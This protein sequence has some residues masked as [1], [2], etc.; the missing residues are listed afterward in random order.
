MHALFGADLHFLHVLGLDKGFPLWLCPLFDSFKAEK[1]IR[2]LPTMDERIPVNAPT[3]E[4]GSCPLIYCPSQ[5][6]NPLMRFEL[7][8]CTQSPS[9]F[10][11]TLLDST[12]RIS[13]SALHF[14]LPDSDEPVQSFLFYGGHF[15][16]GKLINP[17]HQCYRQL[18]ISI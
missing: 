14:C 6:K 13:F 4:N 2:S 17:V 15:P 12:N 11:I 8:S 18:L 5:E 7:T 16:G 9:W 10:N 3:E 1:P